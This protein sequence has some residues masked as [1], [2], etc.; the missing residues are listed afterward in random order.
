MVLRVL[1][2]RFGSSEWLATNVLCREKSDLFLFLV[3]VLFMDAISS[4]IA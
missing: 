3:N 4:K 1:Q 2:G